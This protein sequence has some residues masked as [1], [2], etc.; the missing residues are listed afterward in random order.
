MRGKTNQNH[1][2]TNGNKDGTKKDLI[3]QSGFIAQDLKK[4][5]E[6]FGVDF[7][8]LVYESN[9]E[10]LEATPANLLIPLIK[11]VQELNEK[12]KTLENKVRILENR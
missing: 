9:P 5:Q 7:L 2:Y 6:E 4:L 8:R 1:W 3:V 11:A 10:K 12:V